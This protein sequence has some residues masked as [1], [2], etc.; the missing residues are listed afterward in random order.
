[1][2]VHDLKKGFELIEFNKLIVTTL[3]IRQGS[4]LL[5]TI[6]YQ[7]PR[8]WYW[9]SLLQDI[10]I[11]VAPHFQDFQDL[12]KGFTLPNLTTLT[13]PPKVASLFIEW[14][15][16]SHLRR[17]TLRRRGSRYDVYRETQQLFQ[18]CF[19]VQVSSHLH[20]EILALEF[21]PEWSV[22]L[23]FI[24]IYASKTEGSDLGSRLSCLQLPAKPHIS[25]LRAIVSALESMN[26]TEPI[27]PD[28]DA[29]IRCDYCKRSG[30]DCLGQVRGEFCRLHSQE[31]LISITK[32]AL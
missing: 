1:M 9:C 8:S 4:F 19:D 25:I 32:Y 28:N 15:W 18:L 2:D 29:D 5:E 21:Y 20:L 16:I 3:V 10:T 26:W 17:L 27:I 24:S 14:N 11:E 7:S 12:A 23:Q 6:T 13:C 31:S 30:R 22:L